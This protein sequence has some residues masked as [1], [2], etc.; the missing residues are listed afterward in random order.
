[1]LEAQIQRLTTVCRQNSQCCLKKSA[2][3]LRPEL[4]RQLCE[5]AQLQHLLAELSRNCSFTKLIYSFPFFRLRSSADRRTASLNIPKTNLYYSFPSPKASTWTPKDSLIVR[6]GTTEDHQIWI[7]SECRAE[8]SMM[9]ISSPPS[10]SLLA[11]SHPF[12]R[13]PIHHLILTSSAQDW[14]GSWRRGEADEKRRCEPSPVSRV[15]EESLYISLSPQ[16]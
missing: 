16:S 6:L 2:L 4:S 1:M 12:S 5:S 9:S 11:T 15:L 10:A 13:S 7:L 14:A 3:G 8:R